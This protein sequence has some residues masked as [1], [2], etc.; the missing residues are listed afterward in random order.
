MDAALLAP[1][2][3]FLRFPS[4]ST[5]PAH[6][7]DVQACAGWLQARFRRMGLEAEVHPTGGHPVVLARNAHQPGRRTVLIY[8]HYDVQPADPV[9]LWTTPPFEP[10]VEAGVLYARGAADNKGQI[11]AHILGVEQTLQEKG[12]LPV[13]LIFL[14]EGEEEIGSPHLEAFLQEHREALRP[15][16]IVI[17]DTGMAGPGLPALTYAL[18]GLT[19]L[20]IR[21]H[22]GSSDLH[23]GSYGGMVPNP[24]TLLARL[25]AGLHDADFRV[26]VP[27]FYDSV[28]PLA[29]WEREAWATLPVSDEAL[30]AEAQVH[31]LYGEAGYTPLERAWARPTLE[32]N[33]I[34]GGY[35]GE[36]T[37]T[38]IPRE[39]F[40]KITCRLVPDQTPA[41]IE[42]KVRAHLE[43]LCP[44]EVRLEIIAGHGGDTFVS[45]PQSAD[46]L[47]AQR[48]VRTV[49]GRDA[50]LVRAGGSIP[51][52]TTFRRILGADILLLGLA[53]PDCAAH[54]PNENFVLENYEAGVRLNRALLEE[55]AG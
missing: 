19:G 4:V 32:I 9:A 14:V 5:D 17:S 34:G 37:K 1:L 23:S 40:A 35:Q 28:R 33:G 11:M 36:G 52:L 51:I 25:V 54:A 6:A 47:A 31:A 42:A 45:D 3:E 26:T 49:W 10:R 8:G 15:D 55:L 7:A 50:A 30:R 43:R 21:L 2:L 12:E 16:V 46:A 48:A 44:P 39:A 29:D 53:N 13:N 20:E 41:E 27:G 24:A 22:A 18:R 38:V